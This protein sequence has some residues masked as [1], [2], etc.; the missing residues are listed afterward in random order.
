MNTEKALSLKELG[1]VTGMS[2]R[3]ISRMKNEKDFPLVEGKI[4]YSDFVI[5]RRKKAG[6]V[7][8]HDKQANPSP[9]DDHTTCG[10]TPKNGSPTALTPHAERLLSEASSPS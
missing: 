1:R 3:L 5:W 9:D 2:Y 7:R 6:L 4:F 10:S 8:R